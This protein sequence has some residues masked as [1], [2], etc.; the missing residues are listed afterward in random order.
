M[1]QV[2]QTTPQQLA[3]LTANVLMEKLQTQLKPPPPVQQQERSLTR[4]ETATLL[5]VSLPTVDTMTL[6]GQLKFS[7]IGRIKRFLYSDV[8]TAMDS[9]S[10]TYGKKKGTKGKGGSNE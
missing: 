8:L 7:R 3:E 10:S 2:E 4:K 1:I 5:G 6:L 9:L